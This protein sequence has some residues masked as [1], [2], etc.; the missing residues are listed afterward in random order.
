M[1][2]KQPGDGQCDQNNMEERGEAEGTRDKAYK[3]L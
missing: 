3:G 1:F 2:K